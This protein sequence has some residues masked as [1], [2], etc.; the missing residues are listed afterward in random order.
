MS[1][2]SERKGKRANL[3][4]LRAGDNSLHQTWLAGECDRNWDLL[5]SYFGEHPERSCTTGI[6]TS[7]DKGP[8][9]PVLKKL[10]KKHSAYIFSYE[11]ICFPDD[12]LLW[13]KQDINQFFDITRRFNL[14]LTQPS[15]T[16]DSFAS[17][18]I[19]LHNPNYLIRLTNYV[20]VMA[21]CFERQALRRCAESFDETLSGWGLEF[22][23]SKLLDSNM[24]RFGI[25]DAVQ[26][27]HTRPLGGPLYNILKKKGLSPGMEEQELFRR[28]DIQRYLIET[29]G[30]I[31]LNGQLLSD[32]EFASQIDRWFAVPW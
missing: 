26:M 31:D 23:W 7:L 4:I 16:L 17:H 8:K 19:T 20:E 18:Q 10:I 3:I 27:R 13:N 14:T 1:E 21:P 24:K 2:S 5:I 6:M 32:S 30:A 25:I 15:L 9:W 28:H 22:L 11:Y 29:V 12:D